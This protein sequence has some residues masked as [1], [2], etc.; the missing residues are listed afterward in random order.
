MPLTRPCRKTTE[1]RSWAELMVAGVP[2]MLFRPAERAVQARSAN[3]PDRKMTSRDADFAVPERRRVVP[4]RRNGS[5]HNSA[6]NTRCILHRCL[7]IIKYFFE[8]IYGSSRRYAI[9]VNITR[10]NTGLLRAMDVRHRQ[11][12]LIWVRN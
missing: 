6:N 3:P 7:C 5:D 4:D 8:E 1:G 9:F 2:A 10:A 12:T 11:K